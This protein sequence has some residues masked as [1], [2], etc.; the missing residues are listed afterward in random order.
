MLD[1]KDWRVASI[2][3]YEDYK[4]VRVYNGGESGWEYLSLRSQV[5]SVWAVGPVGGYSYSPGSGNND[6]QLESELHATDFDF[7]EVIPLQLEAV[8]RL[9]CCQKK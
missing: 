2:L 8:A 7:R 5:S 3:H 6:R 9:I 1:W 4:G